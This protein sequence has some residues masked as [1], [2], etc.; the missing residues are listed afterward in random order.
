[1][2]LVKSKKNLFI[3]VA[4][5]T[6]F[7]TLLRK[8]KRKTHKNTSSQLGHIESIPGYQ[9]LETSLNEMKKKLDYLISKQSA[10]DN[11][12]LENLRNKD[13][14]QDL[15][16]P[17]TSKRIL[18]CRKKIYGKSQFV[19]NDGVIADCRIKYRLVIMVSSY[20]GHEERR[21]IIR[22]TWANKTKWSSL[23]FD[24]SPWT[25]VFNVGYETKN[26]GKKEKFLTLKN[27]ILTQ[28]DMI[29]SNV[30]E[31]YYTLSEKLAIGLDWLY[32]TLH[33]DFVLKTD[34]DVFVNLHNIMPALNSLPE[35]IDYFGRVMWKQPVERKG[36]YKL[37]RV[38]F[39]N[40]HFDPYCSGAGIFARYDLIKK[41]I[42]H[43]KPHKKR[44][45]KFEDA[46]FGS[47]AFKL[48][49]TPSK[50]YLTHFH[51]QNFNCEYDKTIFISHPAKKRKCMES[52]M[53]N[54]SNVVPT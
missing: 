34:D 26:I 45:L 25:V 15:S 20:V 22:N 16:K 14:S 41:M 47:I 38:E 17:E 32:R 21:N 39:A 37:S 49:S 8:N 7:I 40:D 46:Y 24:S 36:R 19:L 12:F 51:Y 50:I 11:K 28:G 35:Y 2:I 29:I 6:I 1:M 43:L 53:A 13:D 18:K 31:S 52:L 48:G 33:F 9:K 3:M 44:L 30:T 5:I 23:D 4:L 42:P 54:V 27:E 10:K